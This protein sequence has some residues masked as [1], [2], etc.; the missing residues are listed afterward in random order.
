[1]L[2]LTPYNTYWYILTPI[3]GKPTKKD[4]TLL[5]KMHTIATIVKSEIIFY[6]PYKDLTI[7][8]LSKLYELV[9][10]TDKQFSL[11][12]HGKTFRSLATKKQLFNRKF[13]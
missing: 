10:I 11:F 13:V 3:K 7:K 9:I 1:M 5:K 6:K 4:L 2:Q 8:P 12:E